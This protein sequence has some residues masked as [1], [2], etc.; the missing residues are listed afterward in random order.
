MMYNFLLIHPC[1]I[2]VIQN[3]KKC[4]QLSSCVFFL[5]SSFVFRNCNKRGGRANPWECWEWG[6]CTC[7]KGG[8]YQGYHNYRWW[9]QHQELIYK[10]VA[11]IRNLVEVQFYTTLLSVNFS[12]T[13]VFVSR[14]YL[15][16]ATLCLGNYERVFL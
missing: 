10:R 2:F 16:V 5:K 7:C 8:T 4:P 11:Q 13:F 3:L 14:Y 1:R 15:W 6:F 12:S 9:W